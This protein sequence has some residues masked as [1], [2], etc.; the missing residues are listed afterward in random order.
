[1]AAVVTGHEPLWPRGLCSSCGLLWPCDP[2]VAQLVD[3]HGLGLPLSA[4]VWTLFE[5]AAY[6]V[7]TAPALA[8][9]EQCIRQPLALAEKMRGGER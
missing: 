5:Q 3:E 8:L 7:P 2:V 6:A 9:Y 1:V 4:A